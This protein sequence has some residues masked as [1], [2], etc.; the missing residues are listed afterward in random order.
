MEEIYKKN[1]EILHNKD[2][3]IEFLEDELIKYQSDTIPFNSIKEE[4]KVQYKSVDA[5][6][7]G[8]TISTNF[9]TKQDTIS[10]FFIKWNIQLEEEEV[11]TQKRAMQNW[12][13]VRL[14]DEKVRVISY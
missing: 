2:A 9:K 7:Y 11:L 14:H 10:T 12:L 13:R 5:M 4:L 1:E 8:K 6:T 3:K